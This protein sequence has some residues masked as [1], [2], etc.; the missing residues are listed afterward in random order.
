MCTRV[1]NSNQFG[2]G[3]WM[4][5]CPFCSA[6]LSSKGLKYDDTKPSQ[7]LNI[8]EYNGTFTIKLY[9]VDAPKYI[10]YIY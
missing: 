3:M 5:Y 2:G 10:P 9:K 7:Y 6:P 8:P 1:G 4:V